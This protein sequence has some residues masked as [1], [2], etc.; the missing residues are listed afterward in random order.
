MKMK[1]KSSVMAGVVF[2]GLS[3]A[4]VFAAQSDQAIKVTI[5]DIRVEDSVY[6]PYYE[7][8]TEQDHQQGAAARWI[9]LGVYFTTEGG[10]IDELDVTQMAT[11][12]TDGDT[13]GVVLAETVHY[14]N[15]EPGD[16]YVYVYLH[17]SYVKR[18]EIDE[19]DLDSAAVISVGGKEMARRESAKHAEA[20]WSARADDG[21]EKGY[22]LNHAE[23]PFW[24]INYDFKEIIRR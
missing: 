17:P 10:W 7:V 14:I 12:K 1:L 5:K 11:K 6:T 15:L 4:P 24:F 2:A 3:A 21:M 9:R 20:G 8:Q 22:L 18:Y 23:T 13:P 19:F 16:H